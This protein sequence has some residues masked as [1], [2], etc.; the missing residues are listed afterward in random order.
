M[1][2]FAT[3]NIFALIPNNLTRANCFSLPSTDN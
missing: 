3:H 2:L 1:P